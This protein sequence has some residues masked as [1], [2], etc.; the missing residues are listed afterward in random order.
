MP[1]IISSRADSMPLFC[2]LTS[3]RRS[4]APGGA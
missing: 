2:T 1:E 3:T 4:G